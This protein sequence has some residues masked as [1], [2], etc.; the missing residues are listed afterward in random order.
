MEDKRWSPGKRRR[1]GRIEVK[2]EKEMEAVMK[3]K[4]LTFDEAINGHLWRL[5]SSNRG[6]AGKLIDFYLNL[7]VIW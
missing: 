7:K 3:Q 1:R 5:T 4:H 2:W 6:T